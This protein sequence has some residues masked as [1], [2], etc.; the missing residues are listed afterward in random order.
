MLTNT[1]EYA[2]RAVLYI[3]AEG[4]HS[5][6][7]VDTIANALAVPR[8]Y[9]SKVM[10]ALAREGVLRSTRGPH[11]G[12]TLGRPAD[13]ITLAQVIDQFDPIEDR[14]L[15]MRRQCSDADP[16]VAHHQWRRVAIQLRAFFRTTTVADIVRGHAELTSMLGEESGFSDAPD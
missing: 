16:C 10:H 4:Q 13:E 5:L 11:G 3:A 2:L 7:R 8:N 6:L 15:L 1:A 14:C 12:F 9:L